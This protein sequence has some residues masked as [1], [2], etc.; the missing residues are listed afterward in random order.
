MLT[1]LGCQD[2]QGWLFGRPLDVDSAET[3][4]QSAARA[5]RA[6][7]TAA[8]RGPTAEVGIDGVQRRLAAIVAADVVGYSRMMAQDDAWAQCVPCMMSATPSTR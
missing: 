7:G 5:W 8:R 3:L 4:L 1:A 2:G 6:D